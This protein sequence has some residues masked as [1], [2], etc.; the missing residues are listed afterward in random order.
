MRDGVL[1]VTDRGQGATDPVGRGLVESDG[2]E[3]PVLR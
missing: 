3:Q 1:P 2:N